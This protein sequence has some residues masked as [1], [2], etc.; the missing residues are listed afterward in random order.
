M[1][2]NN[3]MI[4]AMAERCS[5]MILQSG[6]RGLA[7]PQSLQPQHLQW[8][9]KQLVEHAGDWPAIKLHRWLGFVQGAMIAN[10]IVDLDGARAMFDQVKN[11]HGEMS[12]DL[13]DHLN[14]DSCFRLE[15][16]G[17]G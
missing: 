1:P 12:A 14:P 17:E 7:Q 6:E 11:A 8:M 3:E 9:C 13:L 16:G 5:D 4:M 2:N 15:L 10:R